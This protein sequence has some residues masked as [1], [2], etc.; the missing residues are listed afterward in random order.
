VTSPA[1]SA[2][3]LTKTYQVYER[4]LDRLAEAV[5][6]RRRHRS[7]HALSDVSF[8]LER[9]EALGLVG[10]NGAGKS[11][12]LK[13]L[14]GIVTPSAGSVETHG[15]IASI[16]ELGSGFH[17][18]FTG[19]QNAVL[20]AAMLG[21]DERAVHERLPEIL[22]WS[23]LG[24][25]L[26][27]PVKC[28]S[29]GMAMRLGFSIATQVNPDILIIDE[30]LSVGDGYFQKKCVDRLQELVARG[31]TL[32]FC[33]HAMYYISA[34]CERALWLRQGRVAALGPAREV[35]AAYEGH[36]A[37]RSGGGAAAVAPE[38]PPRRGPARLQEVRISV[39]GS[40]TTAFPVDGPLRIEVEWESDSPEHDFHVGIG[41]NREDEVEVFSFAT[42]HQGLPA[43][44]GA[45][46][47]RAELLVP[48]LPLRKGTFKVYVFLLDGAGLH[49]YDRKIVPQAL[50][51]ALGQYAPGFVEAAHRWAIGPYPAAASE[52]AAELALS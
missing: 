28:Y 7:F 17:P 45:T 32:L 6:G 48:R 39:P 33:S 18:E 40:E 30:A 44:R 4:P 31:T 47:Y 10:E 21:L 20:N 51:A 9:G 24:D 34:F 2:V 41:I 37:A 5:T 11:T 19:R 50:T 27:Q 13:I 35:V 52:S 43:V 8:S 14:A 12:L 49:I 3:G 26:D 42:H 25:F 23:E 38:E 16:L 15:T 36:L 29:T 46:R 22:A 1:I